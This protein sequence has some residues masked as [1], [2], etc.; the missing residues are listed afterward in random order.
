LFSTKDGNG[1]N[2]WVFLVMLCR[3]HLWDKFGA[4]TRLPVPES[5]NIEIL[6]FAACPL[7]SNVVAG[8]GW[9][10]ICFSFSNCMCF[11]TGK[12]ILKC[13]FSFFLFS[14]QYVNV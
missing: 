12:L 14:F 10:R 4:C 2:S 9:G 3:Y 11:L 6:A 7:L 1:K 5:W 8:E 13:N